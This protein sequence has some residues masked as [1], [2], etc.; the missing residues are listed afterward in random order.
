MH[1]GYTRCYERRNNRRD[2]QSIAPAAKSKMM[3][4]GSGAG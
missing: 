1:P 2:I 4:P 3:E